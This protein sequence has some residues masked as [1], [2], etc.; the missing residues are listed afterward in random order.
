VVR[1]H[2]RFALSEVTLGDQPVGGAT[3]DVW[4]DA[5]GAHRWS[6][7]IV[8]TSRDVPPGG[9]LAGRTREGQFVHGH[10]SLV[11]SGPALRGRGAVL[12]EWRGVG[13]LQTDVASG[14][15]A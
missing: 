15:G 5:T 10:V 4:Q 1:N 3:V 14:E 7:R 9:A 12:I 11:G 8:M 13:A 6:A 2:R